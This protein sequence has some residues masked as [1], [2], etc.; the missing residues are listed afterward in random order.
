MICTHI[1]NKVYRLSLIALPHYRVYCER[2]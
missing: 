2:V 1:W